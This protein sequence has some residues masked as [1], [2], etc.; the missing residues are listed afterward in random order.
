MPIEFGPLVSPEWLAQHLHD[1]DLRVIDFRWYLDGRSGR[2]AYRAGHIPGAVFLDL[3]A[4]TGQTGAGR[5][6]LPTMDRFTA[7]VRAAGISWRSR[8]VVYDDASG[9][10]GAR[11]WWLLRHFGH[12]PVA[13]LDG[14]IPAWTGELA[15]GDEPPPATGDYVARPPLDGGVVDYREVRD[16]ADGTVLIDARVGARYRGETEPIDPR[17]GH[18]PGAISAPY[19][20]SVGADGRF[21]SP[22]Q[23]RER[24]G[25]I[26][27]ADGGRV[28]AYCGSG[29]T[30]TH[31]LLALE[32]AGLPGARL[33][34]G[35]WSDW[36]SRPELPAAKGPEP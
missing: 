8:V 4:V 19:S 6:P 22:A 25:R 32:V 20:D 13:V 30:A 29:V 24:F 7:A 15:T 1:A 17:A 31:D 16:R 27:I 36:S 14:G 34:A 33:Y 3:E 10:V 11:L 5:H 28:V 9:S 35:S 21:L 18:I 23:L 26:G 2:E 12:E